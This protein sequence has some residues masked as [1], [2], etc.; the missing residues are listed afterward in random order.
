MDIPVKEYMNIAKLVRNVNMR[1]N[2]FNEEE[3]IV[4]NGFYAFLYNSRPGF[5]ADYLICG[6]KYSPEFC[7][8]N[9]DDNRHYFHFELQ[10]P[11]N[12]INSVID[13]KGK[14]PDVNRILIFSLDGVLV[15]LIDIDDIMS[16]IIPKDKDMI[17]HIDLSK[18]D[19]MFGSNSVSNLSFQFLDPEIDG[20]ENKYYW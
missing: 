5:T 15:R 20:S 8:R 11:A 18:D 1:D 19:I 14:D 4:N 2:F 13:Q 12:T 9:V 3:N 7:T 10:Y 17:I 16:H 6:A